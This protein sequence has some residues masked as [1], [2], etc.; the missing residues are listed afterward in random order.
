MT[1]LSAWRPAAILLALAAPACALGDGTT[2]PA[3]EATSRLDLEWNAR[4]RQERVDDGAFARDAHATTLRLRAGLRLR[5]PGGFAALVEGEGVAAADDR[6]NDGANG[7]ASRPMIADPRG[8]ELNQAWVGWK[9]KAV[10]AT[11]GRQRLLV[12]NQRWIGNSGWR[13][14]EQTFDAVALS[15]T[16]RAGT[17]LR[18]AW[19]DRVHR[20]A[21]DAAL[22]P[23]ARARR[24]DTQVLDLDWQAGRRRLG[25]FVVA[26]RDRD[27]A[28]ASARTV[29][30]RAAVVPPGE[31]GGW[32]L[33][34]EMARQHDHARN[35][36][37]FS[38]VY[39]RV[40]P[41]WML[42]GVT[43]RAGWEHLGG[44]G[45][46][47]LQAPLGTLH[48]FNGLADKFN[49]TP[50]GGLEDRYISAGGKLR[51]GRL[52]WQVTWHHYGADT[53]GDYGREWNASLAFPVRGSL[54]GLVKLAD[55]RAD[56]FGRDTRKAWLQLEWTQ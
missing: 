26:H 5:L 35:P 25:A 39:W 33:S 51:D 3:T 10:A 2:P 12:A 13:Q 41:A 11:V 48:G 31:G 22:D 15:W 24:L 6:H 32:G 54:K 53:G 49:A 38:H 7:V 1:L 43:L 42:H 34:L 50:P 21:G 30:V 45:R 17:T 18:H 28:T 44:D 40:E 27:V 46:H 36:Q 20:I 37:A 29:G 8:V 23:R 14:N 56:R 55:Y 52:D 16:P 19:L 4:L 47:A 9:G